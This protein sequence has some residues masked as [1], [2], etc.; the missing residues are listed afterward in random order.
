VDDNLDVRVL[1]KLLIHRLRV[2][3]L[4]RHAPDLAESFSK[5][6]TDADLSLAKEISKNPGVTS[7]A[8]RT[9][10]DAFGTMAYAAVPHLPLELAVIEICGKE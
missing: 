3:L 5:E 1:T 9:I 2:V 10:L 7:D 8:L 6:L 4:L